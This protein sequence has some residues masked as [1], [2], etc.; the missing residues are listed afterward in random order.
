MKSSDFLHNE[1]SLYVCDCL[2][3]MTPLTITLLSR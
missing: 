2:D 1:L 3:D